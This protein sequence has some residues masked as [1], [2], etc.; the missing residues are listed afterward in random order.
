MEHINLELYKSRDRFFNL[1]MIKIKTKIP[2]FYFYYID[3]YKFI[4]VDD[5]IKTI[6]KILKENYNMTPKNTSILWSAGLIFFGIRHSRCLLYPASL[7]HKQH[8]QHHEYLHPI[9]IK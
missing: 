6:N 8:L 2:K 1:P 9:Y 7:R 3:E 4:A 5:L